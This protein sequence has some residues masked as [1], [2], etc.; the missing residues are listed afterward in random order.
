[1]H[2]VS[3][4]FNPVHRIDEYFFTVPF[5]M[6]HIA[7]SHFCMHHKS[8]GKIVEQAAMHEIAYTAYTMYFVRISPIMKR[9]VGL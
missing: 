5:F 3:V 4:P 2:T 7:E 8:A 1:M 6:N 9:C